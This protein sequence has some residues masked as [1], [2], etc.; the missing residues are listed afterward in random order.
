MNWFEGKRIVVPIDLGPQSRLAVDAALE[1]V[2]RPSDVHIIHVAPDLAAV[3]P[4]GVWQ[5]IS[6]EMRGDAVKAEYEREFSDDKYHNIS[7]RV[8]FGD[9]GHRI[10]EFAEEIDADVIVMPSH[11]RTGLKRLLIGSV[12]ERVLRLAHCPVLVLKRLDRQ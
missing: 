5:E 9:P 8:D 11:G 7:F 10:A 4:E 12:A 1:M 6:D 2:F 3:A